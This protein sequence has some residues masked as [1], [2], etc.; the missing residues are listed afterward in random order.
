M[1]TP[2]D[3]MSRQQVAELFGLNVMTIYKWARKGLLTPIKIGPKTVRF[4]RS[5]VEALM[6]EKGK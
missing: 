2:D 1:L 6:K 3:L 4:R 5:D